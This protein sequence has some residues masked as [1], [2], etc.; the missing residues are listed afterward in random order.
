MWSNN[1]GAWCF[2]LEETFPFCAVHW[3]F[4][5]HW[6]KAERKLYGSLKLACVGKWRWGLTTVEMLPT[7]WHKTW[8]GRNRK[9]EMQLEIGWSDFFPL[10]MFFTMRNIWKKCEYLCSFVCNFLFVLC[11]PLIVSL[12]YSQFPF[13]SC[14]TNHN[15][16]WSLATKSVW[17]YCSCIVGEVHAKA[18]SD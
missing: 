6:W 12:K 5:T 16:K 10:L 7:L 14:C 11:N 2:L 8:W 15:K 4:L 18:T 13:A 1:Q 9:E 3:F 17:A